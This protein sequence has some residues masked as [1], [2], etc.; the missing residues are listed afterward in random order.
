VLP[1]NPQP[2]SGNGFDLYN[3]TP[4]TSVIRTSAG[5]VAAGRLGPG[6]T[7]NT[8]IYLSKDGIHWDP[9][10]VFRFP[11]DERVTLVQ[12]KH[13]DPDDPVVLAVVPVS[14]SNDFLGIFR[15]DDG[16]RSF[17]ALNVVLPGKVCGCVLQSR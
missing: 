10:P 12:A 17:S 16:G 15:S 11:T 6:D 14:T 7:T 13:N 5:W 4:I 8:A 3:P 2:P 1:V 9:S